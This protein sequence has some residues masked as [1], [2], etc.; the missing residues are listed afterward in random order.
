[1][2]LA[3]DE[4]EA[5]IATLLARAKNAVERAQVYNLRV[6]RHTTVGNF[7]SA[8]DA[9]RE[10]LALLGSSW[11]A[12][13]AE[14]EAA[15]S[16]EL[17]GIEQGLAGRPVQSL[18]DLPLATDPAKI[19][20][21]RLL[22]SMI[23]PAFLTSPLLHITAGLKIA[24]LSLRHGSSPMSAPGYM[25]QAW[26]LAVLGG[27]REEA[28]ELG[29]AALSL[30]ERFKDAGLSARLHF[31]L[32]VIGFLFRHQTFVIEH[33]E[34]AIQ[35][36]SEIADFVSVSNAI[37]H[38]FYARFSIGEDLGSLG[39]E[40]DR[41]LL[42]LRRTKDTLNE[43]L[44]LFAR[45]LAA[46]L[47]GRTSDR[48]LLRSSSFDE[49]DAL[50]RA[51]GGGS[52]FPGCWYYLIRLRLAY[53]HGDVDGALR[54]MN[55]AEARIASALGQQF[56]LDLPYLGSLTLLAAYPTAEPA[57]Q[58]ELLAALARY[59]RQIEGWARQC[60]ENFEHR[61]LLIAAERMR[62]LGRS[63]DAASCYDQAIEAAR[64]GHF[65]PDE[66]LAY[67]LCARFWL[68]ERRVAAARLSMEAAY[69]A[70]SRWGA[71][72]KMKHL[73]ESYPDLVRG[74]MERVTASP[75]PPSAGADS[76]AGPD[77][78]ARAASAELLDV[79]TVM[80][81]AQ[82]ISSELN[83]DRLL[84]QLMRIVIK[85]AGA[86]RGFLIL[87]DEDR[88]VIEAILTGIRANVAQALVDLGV[89]LRSIVTM[90]TLKSGVAYALRERT[91]AAG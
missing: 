61:R 84:E 58:Q 68:G 63:A 38:L 11:P 28:Y 52:R 66:A 90:S 60:P 77:A 14:I 3:S 42:I 46:A 27:K 82:A 53:L 40:L 7:A 33:L 75:P 54:A 72:A 35:E 39:D 9:G 80:H 41:S 47:M 1:M 62:A 17:A 32:G 78:G 81:A 87:P 24:N 31:V 44:I 22:T 16:A 48:R 30:N 37:I 56:S 34:R 73:Q 25:S 43:L 88:L 51:E 71:I 89:E 57:Q 70:Y 55:E 5:R 67:E 76:L 21:M 26:Y 50:A 29:Q 23:P 19:V 74:A 65:L 59:E 49:D 83:F 85:S 15:L 18:A 6:V 79:E 20:E 8:L 12:T 45:Q 86:Q 91:G 4:A 64:A 10:A 13:E 2:L 69:R 36:G